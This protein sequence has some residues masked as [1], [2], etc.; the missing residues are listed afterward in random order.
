MKEFTLEKNLINVRCVVG[1]LLRKAIVQ[2]MKNLAKAKM[3][4][5]FHLEKP[6]SLQVL[7]QSSWQFKVMHQIIS[8]MLPAT[9]PSFAKFVGRFSLQNG[10]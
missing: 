8:K 3:L 6:L 7:L 9:I 4:I 2:S 5:Q 1:L 10:Y